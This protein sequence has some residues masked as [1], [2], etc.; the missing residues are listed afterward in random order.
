M[1]KPTETRPTSICGQYTQMCPGPVP[2]FG[3]TNRNHLERRKENILVWEYLVG[4]HIDHMLIIILVLVGLPE[5]HALAWLK[6]RLIEFIFPGPANV[7][8]WFLA[9]WIV[10]A[11]ESDWCPWIKS[12]MLA[13]TYTMPSR[14]MCMK[15][16]KCFNI[17]RLLHILILLGQTS[18]E[19]PTVSDMR[20]FCHGINCA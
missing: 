12:T 7:D 20:N 16:G 18:G 5:W 17:T 14:I 1:G 10:S 9:S 2:V 19:F 15:M 13:Y 4:W 6:V 11:R 8:M 3:G